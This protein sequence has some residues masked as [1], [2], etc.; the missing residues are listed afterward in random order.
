MGV[1]DGPLRPTTNTTFP[2]ASS[3][4]CRRPVERRV[5]RGPGGATM[6]TPLWRWYP[7]AYRGAP[8]P[9]PK[10]RG[11]LDRAHLENMVEGREGAP[12]P[13]PPAHRLPMCRLLLREP[14]RV[15]RLGP[16][17]GPLRG[18]EQSLLVVEQPAA[19]RTGRPPRFSIRARSSSRTSRRLLLLELRLGGGEHVLPVGHLH[20]ELG[21]RLRERVDVG[22]PVGEIRDVL[23]VQEEVDAGGRPGHVGGDGTLVQPGRDPFVARPRAI[24]LLLRPDELGRDLLHRRLRRSTFAVGAFSCT[25]VAAS[26]PWMLAGRPRSPRAVLSRAGRPPWRGRR[27]QPSLATDTM[28]SSAATTATRVDRGKR[29]TVSVM[30]DASGPREGGRT[31]RNSLPSHRAPCNHPPRAERNRGA[32]SGSW[33]NADIRSAARGCRRGRGTWRIER[34]REP[35]TRARRRRRLVAPETIWPHRG[36]STRNTTVPLGGTEVLFGPVQGEPDRAGLE[37]RPLVAR[38]IRAPG[39]RGRLS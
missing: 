4:S 1:V 18:D 17:E 19:R 6:S 22:E 38:P 12:V 20:G 16:L 7:P 36:P 26:W 15:A 28:T 23:G 31:G 34:T 11:W 25:W 10:A 2:R 13:H 37:L 8:N 14:V 33:V 21:V 3:S 35:R 24:E 29:R 5:D 30:D 32:A 27:R 39:A 9:S